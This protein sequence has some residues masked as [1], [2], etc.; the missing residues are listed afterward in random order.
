MTKLS[1]LWNNFQGDIQKI[2]SKI[3][4]M[5][6][7]ENLFELAMDFFTMSLFF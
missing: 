6:S 3:P 7:R 4:K 5:K 2:I 1:K